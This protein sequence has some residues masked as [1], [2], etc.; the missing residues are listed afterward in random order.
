MMDAVEAHGVVA[1]G[2]RDLVHLTAELPDWGVL[3]LLLPGA[4]VLLC[5]FNVSVDDVN[6][7]DLVRQTLTSDLDDLTIV[8]LDDGAACAGNATVLSPDGTVVFSHAVSW[9]EGE[10]KVVVI[11]ST[12]QP[13]VSSVLPTVLLRVATG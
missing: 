4:A 1:P 12:D 5:P 2:H 13:A 6:P 10:E 11:T 8:E 7:A 9:V 3:A